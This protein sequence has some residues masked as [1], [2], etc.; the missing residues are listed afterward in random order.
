MVSPKEDC[1]HSLPLRNRFEDYSPT[2]LNSFRHC[3]HAVRIS[4]A[5]LHHSFP[6]RATI[7]TAR[8]LLLRDPEGSFLSDTR[9]ERRLDESQ[10]A[11][12]RKAERTLG[13]R[14]R[15]T[16][17]ELLISEIAGRRLTY[18]KLVSRAERELPRGP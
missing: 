5:E 2:R 13:T 17:R 4:S 12:F 10:V 18:G 16:Q 9:W 6:E 11:A 14:M 1:W 7:E 8:G 15:D 3:V